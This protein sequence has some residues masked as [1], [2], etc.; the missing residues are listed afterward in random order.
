MDDDTKVVFQLGDPLIDSLTKVTE[1]WHYNARRP[2]PGD[3]GHEV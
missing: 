1:C 2:V 3:R